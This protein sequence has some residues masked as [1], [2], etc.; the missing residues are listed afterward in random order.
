VQDANG[1]HY[2]ESAAP[3]QPMTVEQA[4]AVLAGYTNSGKGG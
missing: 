1:I 3:D 2:H 4:L